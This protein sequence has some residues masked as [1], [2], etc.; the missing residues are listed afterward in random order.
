MK[1]LFVVAAA[2]TV[3]LLVQLTL[4]NGLSLPGG[5]VPDLVLLCVIVTGLTG[6]TQAGLVTGFCAGLALDL[7]PPATGLIGQYALVFCLV[8]YGCGRLSFTLRRSALLAF[9]TAACAVIA[10]EAFAA[11]LALLLD[12]PQV[13]LAAVVSVLPSSVLWDL[14]LS[15]LALF[16]AVRTAVALGVS[17]NPLDDS[18][19][20]EQG[21]SAAPAGL[22]GPHLRRAPN[23]GLTS[24]GLG[25]DGV[26]AGSGS[27][28]T[29]D[30][31]AAAAAVGSVGWLR[32]PA[33]TR[34]QRRAQ[35]RMT[36]ALTGAVPR[37]G[38][39]WVGNRPPGLRHVTPTVAAPSGLHRLRPESGVAGSATR[40][41]LPA[42]ARPAREPK[43]DFAGGAGRQ[44]AKSAGT[45]SPKIAFGTGSLP[46]GGR[47]RGRGLPKIAFGTGSLPGGGRR[48]GRGSPKINFSNGAMNGARTAGSAAT[49]SAP[50]SSAATGNGAMPRSP[51]GTGS[52][53]GTSRSGRAGLRQARKI[54]F[55]NGLPRAP[56]MSTGRMAKPR[57]RSGSRSASGSWLAGSRFR[58]SGF[59]G[60]GGSGL[61]GGGHGS[62]GPAKGQSLGGV[63]PNYGLRRSHWPRT[64]R[65]RRKRMSR[66]W[67]RWLR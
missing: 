36:A 1:R 38:A 55:G 47:V 26:T 13:T 27:W 50:D 24:A 33:R 31:A 4:V 16:A 37:K 7:A 15:P 43:I 3:A 52:L 49:G 8:G 10:G 18:P 39:F 30:S 51:F 41:A 19:A 9:G 58:S 14:I 32:G 62:T 23:A 2:I 54:A 11:C 56:K 64:A 67:L 34:R 29:G 12:T 45:G 60:V 25:G 57:F 61:R 44:A 5:G 35:A 42:Q 53:P 40:E 21:G 66:S 20:L 28:L 65:M 63:S 22:A 48:R 59:G 17:F 6:G 46:G